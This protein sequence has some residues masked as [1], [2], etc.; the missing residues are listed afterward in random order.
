MKTKPLVGNQSGLALVLTLLIISFLVAATIQL[1]VTINRQVSFSATQREQVRLDAMILAGVHLARA[2][3]LADQQENDFD[4][5][6]DNWAAF[7]QEML[8]D[9][10]GDIELEITVTDLS[11]RLQVN[12]LV[13]QDSP[14]PSAADQGGRQAGQQY[15]EIWKRFLTSGR[16]AIDNEDQ[17]EALLDA[18]MDWIDQDDDERPQGAEEGYYRAQTPPYGSRNAPVLFLQELL[19]V[20]GMTPKILYGDDEHEGIAEYITVAGDDGRIN[21]NTAPLPVILAV[22]PDVSVEM[23]QEL[24]QFRE[25]PRHRELLGTMDWYRQIDGFAGTG[26]DDLLWTVTGQY[27]GITVQARLDQYRRTGK[28]VLLRAENREQTMLHWQVH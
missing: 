16:F 11:G 14:G 8:A 13:P 26:P 5:L 9:L 15:R 19:L 27:F 20:K 25:D 2:A 22:F 1:M 23:A 6:L 4:S 7:D 18:L 28:G 21:L 10:T 3:L 24:M 12:A 17:A